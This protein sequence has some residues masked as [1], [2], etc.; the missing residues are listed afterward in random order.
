MKAI[1]INEAT[2]SQLYTR[3]GVDNNK[4][5]LNK[6]ID[7]CKKLVKK[8]QITTVPISDMDSLYMDFLA[9]KAINKGYAVAPYQTVILSSFYKMAEAVLG[10]DTLRKCCDV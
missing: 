6:V 1:R 4:A 3:Y 10:I 9:A 5:L 7:K 8:D 2:R